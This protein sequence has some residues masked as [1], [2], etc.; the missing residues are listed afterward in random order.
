[1]APG[2][3]SVTAQ[4]TQTYW[5]AYRSAK[6]QPVSVVV[7]GPASL[8]GSARFGSTLTCSSV[9]GATRTFAW[10][11][12]GSVESS[13]TTASV[14]VPRTWV[15]HSVACRVKTSD[16][17]S[18]VTVTSP[19]QRVRLA[20][21]PVVQIAPSISGTA[22]HGHTLTCSPGRWSPTP[23]YFTYRWRRNGVLLPGEY[24]RQRLVSGGDVGNL[25]SCVVSAHLVGHEV[26]RATS[27]SRRAW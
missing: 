3:H 8:V 9:S 1:M 10:I 2:T 4:F 26:G 19:S 21:A 7:A 11:L 17:D 23:S 18:F 24:D 15:G 12:D 13:L 22:Y 16:A 25:L 6:S 27:R 14:K 5:Y 20:V